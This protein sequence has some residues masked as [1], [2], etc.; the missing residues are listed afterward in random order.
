[1]KIEPCGDGSFYIE[2]FDISATAWKFYWTITS[3]AMPTLPDPIPVHDGDF[4][5]VNVRTIRA[6]V[7]SMNR[8][9]ISTV[10]STPFPFSNDIGPQVKHFRFTKSES[11][12]DSWVLTGSG[13]RVSTAG[14]HNILES[15]LP[16][17]PGYEWDFIISSEFPGSFRIQ[18]RHTNDLIYDPEIMDDQPLLIES[19]YGKVEPSKAEAHWYLKAAEPRTE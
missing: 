4:H 11:G 5:I 9:G 12:N 17:V 15:W 6:L 19:R 3:M 2:K 7:D 16:D 10:H 1:M 13:R 14:G 18:N 8:S